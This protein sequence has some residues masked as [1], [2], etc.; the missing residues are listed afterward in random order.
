M[1]HQDT[2]QAIADVANKAQY[3]GSVIAACFSFINEYAAAIGAL[4]AIVGFCINWWYR[5]KI[6]KLE[7][8]KFAKDGITEPEE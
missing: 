2:A 5:H 1:Q 7:K 6:F 8:A 3:T 4:V